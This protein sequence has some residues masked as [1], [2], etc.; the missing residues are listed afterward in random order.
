M[1]LHK[2]YSNKVTNS[3]GG[4][5]HSLH[6]YVEAQSPT[7]TSLSHGEDNDTLGFF[8]TG[9][10]LALK[11]GFALVYWFR[12]ELFNLKLNQVIFSPPT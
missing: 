8:C 10:I 2:R 3:L 11:G 7:S 4:F 5:R 9:V 1:E 12:A 6:L